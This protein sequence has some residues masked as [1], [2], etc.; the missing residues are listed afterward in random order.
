MAYQAVDQ[1]AMNLSRLC[2]LCGDLLTG[3]VNYV[4]SDFISR[5]EAVFGTLFPKDAYHTTSPPPP[6]KKKKF[7]NVCFSRMINAEWGVVHN[8]LLGPCVRKNM[9]SFKETLWDTKQPSPAS[10]EETCPHD[11]QSWLFKVIKVSVDFILR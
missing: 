5:L 11:K 8:C 1:H 3:R 9:I 7:C 10:R 6:P 2:Q 4:V